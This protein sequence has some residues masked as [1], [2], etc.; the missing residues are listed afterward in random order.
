[1]KGKVSIVTNTPKAAP[2]ATTYADIKGQG[3]IPYGKTADVKIPT[4][5]PRLTARGMGAAVKGGGYMGCK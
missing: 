1:M 5:M 4:T 2:K 3:R